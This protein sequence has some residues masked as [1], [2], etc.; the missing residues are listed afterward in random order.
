MIKE[1]DVDKL[2]VMY[3]LVMTCSD[4]Y[5]NNDQRDMVKTNCIEHFE[6]KYNV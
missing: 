4:E 6:I 2:E 1:E 3:K 5:E